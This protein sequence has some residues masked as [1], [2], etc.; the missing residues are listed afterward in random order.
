MTR[1][2]GIFLFVINV[3]EGMNQMDLIQFEDHK[4]RVL[5][6]N[7]ADWDGKQ[8]AWFVPGEVAAAI[9]ASNPS[10][11]ARTVLKRNTERFEGFRGRVKLTLP[12][13]GTQEINIINENGLYMFLMASDLPKAVQFQRRVTELL[14]GIRQGKIKIMQPENKEEKLIRAKAMELNAR[15]RQA[16]LMTQI[17]GQFKGTLSDESVQ[18]LLSGATEVLVGAP[19]LPKPDVPVLFTATEIAEEMDVTANKIGRLS[20]KHNLKTSEYG[21]WIL[22]KARGHDKQVRSFVYNEKGR[23]RLIDLLNAEIKN[24]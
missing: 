1:Y 23:A 9:G 4:V 14:K 24:T 7:G 10:D 18:L 21:K 12:S 22:D 5:N 11:Y 8:E 6:H 13:G 3:K 15:T 19:I 17:A 2:M 16:K 20:N